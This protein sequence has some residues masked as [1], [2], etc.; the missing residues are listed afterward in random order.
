M[1]DS[2]R[3]F[4]ALRVPMLFLVKRRAGSA[5]LSALILGA[6]AWWAKAELDLPWSLSQAPLNLIA[7]ALF[8]LAILLASDASIH[9]LLSSLLPTRYHPAIQSLARTF[10]DQT[11]ADVIVGGLSAA[12]EEL[13][14]RGGVLLAAVALLSLPTASAVLISGAVFGL[15]HLIPRKRLWPFAIWAAWEGILLGLFYV[16]SGSLGAVALAHAMHDIIGFVIFRR[17]LNSAPV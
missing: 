10:E 16:A 12:S 14:F 4:S 11:P 8:A 15:A 7:D 5:L 6:F 3:P 2:R 13:L 1:L 9:G 17:I